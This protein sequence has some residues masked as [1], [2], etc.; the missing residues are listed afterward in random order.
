M[1]TVFGRSPAR[2]RCH[3]AGCALVDSKRQVEVVTEDRPW[4]TAADRIAPRCV[5][6]MAAVFTQGCLM[7]W[8]VK[9]SL[10]LVAAQG[11]SGRAPDEGEVDWFKITRTCRFAPHGFGRGSS[12][13]MGL[14]RSAGGR[15][16]A[17]Q[18]C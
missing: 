8:A 11:G 13:I 14:C 18:V 2:R 9:A 5:E 17:A 3:A 6:L 16:L 7:K 12:S 1:T 4:G 15:L 10:Q